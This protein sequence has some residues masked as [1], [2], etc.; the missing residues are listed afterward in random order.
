[1]GRILL[2]ALL[3]IA[4]SASAATVPTEPGIYNPYV[5]TPATMYFHINGLQQFPI[6]TQMPDDRYADSPSRGGMSH[7]GCVSDPVGAQHFTDR[8]AHTWYGFSSP[9]IVEY[10]VDDS[11]KPRIH[12][13]RGLSYDV[14][15]DTTKP[16]LFTWFL[17]GKSVVP[18]E[19]PVDPDTYP[20]PVPQVVVRAT[21]REGD[22]VSVGDEAFNQG[23]RIAFGESMPTDLLGSATTT[24]EHV[25][26]HEVDGRYIYQFTF[27]LEYDTD[28]ITKEEGYNIRVDA[29]M[30]NEYC[31]DP[32]AKNSLMLDFTRVHTSPAYRPNLHWSIMNPLYVE[33]MHPQF[34]GD[35]LVVHTE[36]NSPWGSYDVLGDLASEPQIDL[37]FDGPTTVRTLQRI[38]VDHSTGHGPLYHFLPVQATWLWDYEA[39]AAEDGTYRVTI[40][41]ENDQRTAVAHAVSTFQIGGDEVCYPGEDGKA[42][43]TKGGPPTVVDEKSPG[44]PTLALLAALV[45][46]ALLR[47][48]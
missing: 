23:K 30:K 44:V 12:P 36:L 1:M 47:R 37:A 9:S 45:G 29:Y 32:A 13:E 2:V 38:V 28:T 33:V 17:E 8:S 34:V 15:L 10:N 48:K 25:T 35:D 40:S 21:I 46:M 39:D 14:E 41:I 31:S 3:L 26:V 19:G 18:V 16:A 27:P 20:T 43:C 24:N 5:S 6:N 4:G 7:S 11:G 22:D 42:V